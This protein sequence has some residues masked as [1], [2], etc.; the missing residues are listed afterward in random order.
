MANLKGANKAPFNAGTYWSLEKP[1]DA[2]IY[3]EHS[4]HKLKVILESG[5]TVRGIFLRV[6]KC[7]FICDA[8]AKAFILKIVD[9]GGYS[10]CPKCETISEY[11]VDDK[12]GRT[13]VNS[14]GRVVYVEIDA[15]LRD[16]E[17]F[18]SQIHPD[19]SS[20]RKKYS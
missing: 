12:A 7:T 5:I 10:C 3:L 8:P 14:M 18:R 16:N 9:H 15:P 11:M 13:Q 6:R 1:F 17:S 4:C 2:N 19:R 20:Q